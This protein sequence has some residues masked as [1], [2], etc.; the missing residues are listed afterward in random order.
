MS[1]EDPALV[2]IPV[3]ELLP[4]E[5]EQLDLLASIPGLTDALD[6]GFYTDAWGDWNESSFQFLVS[7]WLFDGIAL[8]LP[9]LPGLEFRIGGDP[10]NPARIDVSGTAGQ[11]W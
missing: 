3:R 10:A 7:V 8:G 4:P 6:N 2:F 11:E 5:I 1:L 9:W